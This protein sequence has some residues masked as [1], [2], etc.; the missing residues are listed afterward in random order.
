MVKVGPGIPSGPDN[1]FGP[2]FAPIRPNH[3]DLFIIVTIYDGKTEEIINEIE[4]NYGSA[5]HRKYL[6]R[7]TL[8][9]VR[10]GHIIETKAK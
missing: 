10:N 6:G 7:L 5:D 4:I 8:W 3:D 1:P 2:E 9:S